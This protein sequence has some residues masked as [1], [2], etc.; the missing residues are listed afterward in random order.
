MPII[1]ASLNPESKL[2]LVTIQQ[3]KY[4][5]NRRNQLLSNGSKQCREQQNKIEMTEYEEK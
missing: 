5:P 4:F 3:D 2:F 1:R